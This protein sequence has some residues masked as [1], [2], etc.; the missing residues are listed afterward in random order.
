MIPKFDVFVCC[1]EKDY[2]KLPYVIK[3]I[4]D[5][6]VGYTGIYVSTPTGIELTP[7]ADNVYFLK[8][9]H[10]LNIDKMAWKYRHA[11]IYQQFLKLFQNVTFHDYYLTI[12][13]DTI[14]NKKL[15]FFD[16]KDNP[17]WYLGSDSNHTP[18]FN[19]QQQMIDIGKVYPHSFVADMNFFNKNIIQEML[20][21]NNMTF[22]T[23]LL[24]SQQIIDDR[25]YP[26]EPELYGSYVVIR[27]PG[28]YTIK[29]LKNNCSG[30]EQNNIYETIYT[31][32]EL[33]E[34][35]EAMKNTDY[36]IF[37]LHSWCKPNLYKY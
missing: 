34:S 1:A 37:S 15:K 25:C 32:A 5:N 24:K 11:W 33:S 16:E 10:V 26:A 19:F 29:Q 27:H 8:D 7:H 30:K 31:D 2:I 6:V 28:L 23:F 18:Y 12:D 36:D 22:D 3:A 35:I 4:Q 21:K 9:M 17:I 20:F 14:I 13:A